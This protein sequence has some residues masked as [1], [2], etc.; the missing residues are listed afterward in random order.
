MSKVSLGRPK[1]ITPEQKRARFDTT[2]FFHQAN[3]G[4]YRVDMNGQPLVANIALA[5]LNGYESVTELLTSIQDIDQWYVDPQR[6]QVFLDQLMKEGKI[7]NFESEVYR[8]KTGERIW[9]SEDGWLVCDEV[10]TPLYYEGTIEDITPRKQRERFQEALSEM[11]EETLRLGPNEQVYKTLLRRAV[12]VIPGSQAGSILLFEHDHY[13]YVAALGF[14]L[15]ALKQI[16]FHSQDMPC[17]HQA[18]SPYL[19]VPR[20][21]QPPFYGERLDKLEVSGRLSA[22]QSTLIIPIV[23]GDHPLAIINLD[24]FES[25]EAFNGRSLE[26]A[27][28]LAKQLVTV[29]SRFQLEAAIQQRQAMLEESAHFH[30]SLVD[31]MG[32]SLRQGQGED[33]YTRL[34]QEAVKVVPGA[35]AGSIVR[36]KEGRFH[37]IASVGFEAQE[38]EQVTFSP[39]ELSA[40]GGTQPYRLIL[41]ETPIVTDKK[42]RAVLDTAGRVT[43]IKVSLSVPITLNSE[44]E[45][46]LFLDNFDTVH[47]FDARAIDMSRI[48]GEQIGVLLSRFELERALSERQADLATWGDFYQGLMQLMSDSLQHGLN[49][50]FYQRLLERA[51][52]V[53][54]GAQMGSIILRNAPNNYSFVAS[55][56]FDLAGLKTITLAD[57][58]LLFDP[59]NPAPQRI[60]RYQDYEASNDTTQ[61]VLETSGKLRELAVTLCVPIWANNALAALLFLDNLEDSEAFTG[62]SV[63][64]A[65]GF[66]HQVAILLQR[67]RLEQELHQRQ[68]TLERW[69]TFQSS[70]ITFSNE[71]LRRGETQTLYHDLLRHA[72]SVIPG[73]E[74]GSILQR[75]NK[76]NYHFVSALNFDL[77]ALQS[78]TLTEDELYYNRS[79]EAVFLDN[80]TSYVGLSLDSERLAVLRRAGRIDEIGSTLSVPVIKGDAVVAVL[81]L[82]AF[83]HYAFSLETKNMAGAYAAQMGVLL[84]RL[85]L[86]T[87]LRERQSELEKGERFRS[88]LIQFMS[89]T[90][91]RGLDESFY[92]RLLEHAASVIPG[93]DAGSILTRGEDGRYTFVAA[94][95]HDLNMLRQVTF[96]RHELI[97]TNKNHQPRIVSNLAQHNQT[98]LDTKRVELLKQAGP[99]LAIKTV[100]TI[101]VVLESQMVATLNLDAFRE[102][103]FSSEALEMAY[104][105]AT[106]IALLLQRLTLEHE[107]EKSNLELAKLANYDALTG[108]PNRAL[109]T[110]RLARTIAK[111]QRQD[112]HAALIFLDL[113]GFKLINDSL[114]HSVG[115]ELLQSVAERLLTCVREDDTVARLGGDEFTIILSSL[116]APQDA[117]YVAEKV[118]DTLSQPFLLGG[119][120]LHIGAS[121]GITL[122]PDDGTSVEELVQHADTAM[123]HAKALG[124][125]RYHFFTSELNAKATEQLRLE[126][127]MRS[128][129]ERGEFSLEFQPRVQLQTN[130]VTSCEALLRWKHPELGLISPSVLVPI[131]EKSSFIQTL[132]RE[133]LR[134]ACRQAKCWQ[135]AG[136]DLRVAVNVSVKQLQQGTLVKDVKTALEEANLEAKWLELEITESAAMT[137]VESNIVTLQTLKD[138]GVYISIDDF[139]TAYSSLNYLKRLPINSLK[140]DK[141]FVED[142]SDTV[143]TDTAIV[144]AVIALG[145][146]LGFSLIAEGVED[147]KQLLFLRG[148]G[149]DEAQGY[150]FSRP[151]AARAVL[152]WLN[153]RS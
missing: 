75:D 40:N 86:E 25:E 149:C 138:M 83:R 99:P 137:D 47:A 101:P 28:I 112:D 72:A 151:M 88:N 38:L 41:R 13:R 140:I 4:T 21:L 50:D 97:A 128:G 55:V 48:F 49:E 74:A 105:F 17:K 81:N 26:L 148:A 8:Y 111:T 44:I 63:R 39:E 141:S 127:D 62:T 152:D 123:Y 42:R 129:L 70:L 114:G 68:E 90:L 125:N 139:G 116:K 33:F 15:E 142:I 136:H 95:G 93:A 130:K 5:R 104:A 113:D 124:K 35:Q 12:R 32:A 9:V 79:K 103:A 87:A 153:K 133:V 110:D 91:R 36:K 102:D 77:A 2:D 109:F 117:I 10:G 11:V 34:L 150:Y 122:Y 73:V 7:E 64:M 45:A 80:E 6:R 19:I 121:L 126:N 94:L 84:Q 108:L 14:D 144:Q 131:A 71:A 118:L 58:D 54:P 66:A 98:I 69:R 85:N 59:S 106:Q 61:E 57:A 29:L 20:T 37:F 53:V 43:D 24:N 67:L 147:D 120:D 89:E 134:Q 107:L 3:F 65:E 92:Q 96:A 27:D 143:S 135:E 16:S 145:K 22:I 1:P 60:N 82:N 76:G 18:R 23:L 46:F 146:S 100:L 132:G 115:D 51:V 56:G 119:R 52:C 30:H 31:F 78:I